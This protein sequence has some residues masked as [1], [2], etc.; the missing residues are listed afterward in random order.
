MH[1]RTICRV[2]VEVSWLLVW[3]VEVKTG[4]SASPDAFAGIAIAATVWVV[5]ETGVVVAAAFASFGWDGGSKC[6]ASR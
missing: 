4:L 1:A 5:G 3:F 6:S 2:V